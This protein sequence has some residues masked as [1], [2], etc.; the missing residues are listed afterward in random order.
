[1][2]IQILG[3]GCSKCTKLYEMTK[4]IAAEISPDAEIVKVRDINAIIAMGVMMTPALVVDG[5][6]KFSGRVPTA[7]ELRKALS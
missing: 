3:T 2:K 1:M 6:I 4:E 7:D 5:Q